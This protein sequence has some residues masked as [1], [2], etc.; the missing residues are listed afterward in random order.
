MGEKIVAGSIA[1]QKL[2]VKIG[3]HTYI[4]EGKKCNT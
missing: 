2:M 1:F 4:K 3:S